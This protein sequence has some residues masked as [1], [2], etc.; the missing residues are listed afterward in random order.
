MTTGQR[1]LPK[2]LQCYEDNS[3]ADGFYDVKDLPCT[4]TLFFHEKSEYMFLQNDYEISE[5]SVIDPTPIIV[6]LRVLYKKGYCEYD[7]FWCAL[8]E[9][10]FKK[11]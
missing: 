5:Y 2:T 9:R 7:L 1:A 4:R 6:I 10:H 3:A 8:L 11:D